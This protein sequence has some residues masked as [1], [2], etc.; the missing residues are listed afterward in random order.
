ME[1]NWQEERSKKFVE[2][3]F[4]PRASAKE[5]KNVLVQLMQK[6]INLYGR[7]PS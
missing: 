7:R 4:I 3:K 1:R 6:K 2:K 5:T